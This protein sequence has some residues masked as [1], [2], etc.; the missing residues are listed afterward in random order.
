MRDGEIGASVLYTCLSVTFGI[1]QNI[2][3]Y[4]AIEGEKNSV[5][6]ACIVFLMFIWISFILPFFL[7]LKG[8]YNIFKSKGTLC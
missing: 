6:I 5:R 2:T 8:F 7:N 1:I 3:M 4:Y